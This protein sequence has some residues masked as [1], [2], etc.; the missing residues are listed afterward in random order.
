MR[1]YRR[2]CKCCNEW[3]IPKYQN[4][5][6]CNEICGT[7]IALE[8]RSKEREKAEK[9]AEKKRRREEQKQ[10]D[11]LKIRKLALKPRSYWIKQ[12]QQAV[13]AFIR[14][15][16]RDLPCISCG[17]LTSAQWDAG[18][19]RTTAAAPQLRFDERNIHKQCVVCNQHKSGN[20]V[21]YRVMLIE[22]IGIAAV[23]EIESDHKRHRWTTEE[24]K[25]IKAEYQQKLKD[26]RD[27]RS[28]A[29]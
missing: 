21:P 3:F 20:L 16:D 22:R 1:I 4:Q 23:D 28:E 26:L 27:S 19:Y 29:A 9:A 6:W 5:Y 15:R 18:H 13:N 25:A 7:K 11:K 2:K 24:C 10:K 17:T 14:E 8:R 12:A